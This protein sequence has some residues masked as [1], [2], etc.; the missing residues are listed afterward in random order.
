MKLLLLAK[1]DGKAMKSL[2]A[3]KYR[4]DIV[5]HEKA[6][7]IDEAAL[8]ASSYAV[9][10]MP[11]D[12]QPVFNTLKA[13]QCRAPVIAAENPA[14]NEIARAAA[15]Y[16]ENVTA[17]GI[18]EKLMLLYTNEKLRNQLIKKGEIAAGNFS[19]QQTAGLLRNCI[20][21]AVK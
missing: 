18:G 3:Y 15:L 11:N 20:S 19:I 21:K 12:G 7:I 13:M 1:P 4:N 9:L 5:I 10:I 2:S 17:T 14:V 6:S 8:F 16:A